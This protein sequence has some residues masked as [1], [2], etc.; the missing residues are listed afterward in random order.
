MFI[1]F[2]FNLFQDKRFIWEKYRKA[3]RVQWAFQENTFYT[4]WE[5]T[6]IVRFTS[7]MK[8][9]LHTRLLLSHETSIIV[10]LLR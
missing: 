6:I 7:S 5:H 4:K 2:S 10:I 3:L 8:H 9:T 1:A